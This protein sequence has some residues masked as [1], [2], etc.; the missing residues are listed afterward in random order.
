LN[1][2]GAPSVSQAVLSL[3]AILASLVGLLAMGLAPAPALAAPA[4][5]GEFPLAQPLTPNNELVEGPDGNIWVTLTTT[6]MGNDVARIDAKTLK[7]DEFSL[8]GVEGATGIAAAEGK[9]W[10]AQGGGAT[11]LAGIAS[12]EPGNPP[13]TTKTQAIPVATLNAPIVLGPDGNL[14]MATQGSFG[15]LVRIPPSHPDQFKAFEIGRLEN[16]SD[17]DVA[18]PLL[19]VADSGLAEAVITATPT[20]PPV[21]SEYPASGHLL[22]I[23]GAPSGQVAFSKESNELGLITPPGPPAFLPATG[24]EP[25]GVTF[26]PDGAFWFAEHAANTVTRLSPD[27]NA[28]TLSP[29]FA[30]GAGPSQIAAGP[31]HTLWVTLTTA[32]KVGRIGGVGGAAQEPPPP[33]G[34]TEPQTMLGK[35]PS[36]VV[37]ARGTRAKVSFAF[38]SPSAGAGFECRLAPTA[39]RKGKRTAAPGFSVCRSPKAYRLGPGRYRFEVRAVLA[40]L[41]DRSPALRGFRVARA[42]KRHR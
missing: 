34:R 41:A 5:S 40:G 18:G 1:L 38:S 37:R 22:G 26:G 25:Q 11:I 4:I 23:A 15:R 10:V 30:P 6:G 21:L 16:P 29:R 9:L 31:D 24:A 33:P 36:G 39:A 27:G 8:P 2:A 19:V 17:I 3:R 32:D 42:A 28:A 35:G 14:W 13:A 20:D 12:F 7:V